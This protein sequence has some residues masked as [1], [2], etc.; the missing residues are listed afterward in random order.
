MKDIVTNKQNIPSEAITTMLIDYSFEGKFAC[1]RGD[2][3]IPTILCS[4][5]NNYVKYMLYVI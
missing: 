4:I 3:G 1:K 2:L 5:N